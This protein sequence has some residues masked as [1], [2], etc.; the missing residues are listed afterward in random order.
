M[1]L[2]GLIHSMEE[3]PLGLQRPH[4]S[5]GPCSTMTTVLS[6]TRSL[7]QRVLLSSLEDAHKAQVLHQ[8]VL[9]CLEMCFDTIQ[10]C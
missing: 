9:V 3:L 10:V 2:D 1:G 6:I 4:Q 8:P 7:V 5:R